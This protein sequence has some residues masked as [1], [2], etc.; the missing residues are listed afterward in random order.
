MNKKEAAEL[1]GVSIRALKRYVQEG[2]ISVQ[3]GRISV[4]YEKGKPVLQLTLTL[5]S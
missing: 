1:L 2:R 3:E 5:L 4:R